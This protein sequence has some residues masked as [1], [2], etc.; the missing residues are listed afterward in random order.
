MKLWFSIAENLQIFYTCEVPFQNF[1]HFQI[2]QKFN[3]MFE[4]DH[5]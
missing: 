3:K 2:L 1:I 4:L 5:K